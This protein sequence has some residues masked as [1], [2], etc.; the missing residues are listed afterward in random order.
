MYGVQLSQE[1]GSLLG[2]LV[3]IKILE[4][5]GLLQPLEKPRRLTPNI[6]RKAERVAAF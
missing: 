1:M 4:M 6:L 5:V 3:L 2:E